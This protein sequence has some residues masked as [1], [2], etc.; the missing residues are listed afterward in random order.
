MNNK[1][2]FVALKKVTEVKNDYFFGVTETNEKVFIHLSTI[3]NTIVKKNI[4]NNLCDYDK[5][6][7]I[8]FIITKDIKGWK[9]VKYIHNK[10]NM[11][12]YFSMV[13]NK[14]IKYKDWFE[15]MMREHQNDLRSRSFNGDGTGRGGLYGMGKVIY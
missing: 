1:Y 13:E 14:S 3:A 4:I 15:K 10:K 9:A 12:P 11:E 8:P 7:L 2:Y 6:R 5:D